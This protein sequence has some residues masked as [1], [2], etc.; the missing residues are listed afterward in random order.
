MNDIDDIP[1]KIKDV[2]QNIRQY[3]EID[4]GDIE[5]VRFEEDTGTIELRFLGNCTNCPMSPMT[6][7]AGIEPFIL[8]IDKRILRVESVV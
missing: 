3:L 7:R 5:F 6:L 4:K 1:L 8:N 2:L